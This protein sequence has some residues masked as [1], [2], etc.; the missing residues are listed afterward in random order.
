[1]RKI[2]GSILGIVLSVLTACDPGI[3]I[4][5]Q[6]VS[7]NAGTGPELILRVTT[8]D[9]L[10]GEKSYAPELEVTNSSSSRMIITAVELATS[11]QTYSNHRF[12]SDA[13][14]VSVG[15]SQKE[16]LEVRF[17]LAEP[18]NKAFKEPAELRVHYLIGS[19]GQI[20]VA[21]IIGGPLN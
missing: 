17:D 15:P 10:I 9:Q 1:M 5:Q 11:R 19:A 7:E 12:N 20:A 3:A 6:D 4:R 13:Y 21:H 14:P 8:R 18:V 16:N 2:V